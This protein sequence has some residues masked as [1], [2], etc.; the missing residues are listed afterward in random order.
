MRYLPLLSK[1]AKDGVSHHIGT[2]GRLV[3]VERKWDYNAQHA[4][5]PPHTPQERRYLLKR[6]AIC[7]AITFLVVLVLMGTE[8]GDKKPDGH[9]LVVPA[10]NAAF[11]ALLGWFLPIGNKKRA[12]LAVSGAPKNAG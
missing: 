2:G 1:F 8:L 6:T 3:F 9:L 10:I 11:V 5:S 7:G 12:A 4:T